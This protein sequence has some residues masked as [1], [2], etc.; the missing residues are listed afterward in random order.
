M[1]EVNIESRFNISIEVDGKFSV[2]LGDESNIG[3][4][5]L[6]VGEILKSDRLNG[7]EGAE[8]DA[9]IPETVNV[10]PIYSKE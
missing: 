7:F 2:Y 9:S 4:K 5:L 1:T 10:K 8:I 3:E 6:A